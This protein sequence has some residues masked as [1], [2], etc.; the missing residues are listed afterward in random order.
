MKV[1]HLVLEAFVGPRNAGSEARHLDGD[2]LNN[3]PA[4]LAWSSHA[5]NVT[6]QLKH[7]TRN[8][9]ARNGSARLT[10]AQVRTIRLERRQGDTLTRIA[11]RHGVCM[12]TISDIC[13]RKSWA[14]VE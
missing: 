6:D 3:T 1:H 2:P 11:A 14:H 4:N 5:E 8:R 7:G 12:Q 13:R 9:G 10:E